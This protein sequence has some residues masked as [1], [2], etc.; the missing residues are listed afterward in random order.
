M[1]D[2]LYAAW[3]AACDAAKYL[4]RLRERLHAL[5]FCKW[6]DDAQQAAEMCRAVSRETWQQEQNPTNS[7]NG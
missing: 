7:H 5:G 3:M 6:A 4:E 2:D 1:N